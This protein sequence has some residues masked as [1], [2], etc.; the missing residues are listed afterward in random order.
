MPAIFLETKQQ[1]QQQQQQNPEDFVIANICVA[2][3][4]L[5]IPP[6]RIYCTK[7]WRQLS[8]EFYSWGNG[9]LKSLGNIAEDSVHKYILNSNMLLN[10][11]KE[12]REGRRE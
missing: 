7:S 3:Y 5:Q 2:I 9:D 11:Y 4:D 8:T 6:M 10:L 12:T 1:Q